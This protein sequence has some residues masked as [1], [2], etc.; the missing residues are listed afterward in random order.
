MADHAFGDLIEAIT[1]AVVQA[2]EATERQHF[3]LID[4]YFEQKD[5]TLII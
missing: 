4:Y 3:K 2:R 5:K 1:N